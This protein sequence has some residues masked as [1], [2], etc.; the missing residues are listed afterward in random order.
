M[1]FTMRVVVP[2]IPAS[3]VVELEARF[4]GLSSLVTIPVIT[5][6]EAVEKAA[7]K[8]ANRSLVRYEYVKNVESVEET[9]T[10]W[11]VV[12]KISGD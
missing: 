3:E 5:E 2:R 10:G 9:P 7:E 4:P 1:P 8:I 11:L 12:L 6:M